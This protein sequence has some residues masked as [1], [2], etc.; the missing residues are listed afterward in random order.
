MAEK[1]PKP[2]ESYLLWGIPPVPIMSLQFHE[3]LF[4][5]ICGHAPMVN[6]SIQGYGSELDL[7]F[8]ALEPQTGR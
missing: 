2:L 1:S 3:F 6:F 8:K 5:H 7:A 4:A